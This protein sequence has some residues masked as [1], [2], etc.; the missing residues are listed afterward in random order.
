V[1]TITKTMQLR[2]P[3]TLWKLLGQQLVTINYYRLLR[4]E[5]M[6]SLNSLLATI[7]AGHTIHHAETISKEFTSVIAAVTEQE[8]PSFYSLEQLD[9]IAAATA[10]QIPDAVRIGYRTDSGHARVKAKKALRRILRGKP[11]APHAKSPS[12]PSEVRKRCGGA[13]PETYQWVREQLD[14][15]GD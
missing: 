6:M 3:P 1:N 9:G 4:G 10:E 2:L 14:A 7:L 13:T 5:R 12:M 8:L 15:I 11:S